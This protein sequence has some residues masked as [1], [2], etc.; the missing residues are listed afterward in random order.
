MQD[1]LDATL[2]CE[3]V[4]AHEER[5]DELWVGTHDAD[6]PQ[7]AGTAERADD[8]RCSEG[9]DGVPGILIGADLFLSR[10]E[11]A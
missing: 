7:N 4:S 6:S 8:R 5:V 2:P 9:L 3:R 1:R 10:D 11:D